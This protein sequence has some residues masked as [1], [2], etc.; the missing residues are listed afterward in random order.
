M[1][2]AVEHVYSS[3]GHFVLSHLA[4]APDE[5][6]ALRTHIPAVADYMREHHD[7]LLGLAGIFNG[8]QSPVGVRVP[9]AAPSERLYEGIEECLRAGRERGVF[10][11]FDVHVTAVSLQASIDGMFEY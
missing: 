5:R 4:K 9:R 7:Q 3:V 2:K 11:G 8:M 1:E 6:A 10:R